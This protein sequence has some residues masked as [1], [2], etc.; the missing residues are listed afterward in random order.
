[1]RL[2]IRISVSVTAWS[3]T[4]SEIALKLASARTMAMSIRA[5]VRI[6]TSS[7]AKPHG[8]T[9]CRIEVSQFD[10]DQA[11][12][13]GPSEGEKAATRLPE[14]LGLADSLILINTRLRPWQEMQVSWTRRNVG[15]REPA[16]SVRM[17]D[18][19][20]PRHRIAVLASLVSTMLLASLLPS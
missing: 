16:V 2:P 14:R 9:S 8:K 7:T 11:P 13:I 4:R 19:N 10:L 15:G 18:L 1:M 5:H 20:M 12:E 17:E 3:R 6:R